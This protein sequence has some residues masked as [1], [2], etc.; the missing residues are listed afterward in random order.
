MHPSDLKKLITGFLILSALSGSLT[1]IF[2]NFDKPAPL[3][4]SASTVPQNQNPLSI[5]K[6]AFVE[7]LPQNSFAPANSQATANQNAVQAGRQTIDT[8]NLTQNF[9]GIFAQQVIAHNPDG[10][11]LDQNGKPAGLNLPNEDSA[12]VLIQQAITSSTF[13]VDETI[14]DS[15]LKILKTYAAR[16]AEDYVAAVKSA[17]ADFA[18]STARIDTTNPGSAPDTLALSQLV[19]ESALL[20]L[21]GAPVPQPLVKFH[22]SLLQ[23]FANQKKVLEIAGNYQTD[24]LKAVVVLKN[25]NE[26]VGRDVKR[27]GDEVRNIPQKISFNSKEDN[28]ISFLINEIFGVKEAKA[29]V[30][31]TGITPVAVVV[32][33]FTLAVF[34]KDV[35]IAAATYG[36]WATTIL[37]YVARVVDWIKTHAYEVWKWVYTTAL[38][39]AVKILIDTFENQVVNWIAGNG[40]PKFI[41]DW[42]G[43]LK[44]VGD[45]AAGQALSDQYPFLCGNIGPLIRVAV[46]PVPNLSTSVRCTLTQIIGNVTGFYNNFQTGG[47]IAYGATLQPQNNFFGGLIQVNENIKRVAADA[48]N[49]AG[50]QSVASKGFLP[51]ATKCVKSHPVCTVEEVNNGNCDNPSATVCDKE[52][53]QTPGATVGESLTKALGWPVE[54]IFPAQRFEELVGA[55]VNA[56]INRMIMSGLSALTEASNPA[57]TNFAN[58]IP[59]GV[60]DP[61]SIALLRSN[62]NNLIAFQQ[63]NGTFQRFQDTATANTQWLALEPQ[64]IT[65]LGQVASSCASLA[66]NSQQKIAALNSLKIDVQTELQNASGTTLQSI[67]SQV[68]NAT[69]AQALSDIADRL[70]GIDL[71]V[72]DINN[73]TA[74]SR[75]TRLQNLQI[76]A[77]ANL[78]NVCN[79]Q[80]I[81]A[82]STLQ[83]IIP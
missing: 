37:N 3:S 1:L 77:Q 75:L 22:R 79:F 73:Q 54:G 30:L 83:M 78:P 59:A 44:D 27:I 62:L 15:D 18:S 53:I 13:A 71:A 11:Q 52:I 14:P 5:G 68:N 8:S 28:K 70:Q 82:T 10:P 64:V 20:K 39:I 26:I 4:F 47:W 40:N 65:L 81:D 55:I 43:F 19:F 72:A 7:Q 29:Q 51:G 63:R 24:P 12:A 32:D 48:L 16:D 80:L 61:G 66:T 60:V 74:A 33:P 69:S 67:Q 6:N 17:L 46:L 23:F 25:E 34:G 38:R 36:T 41:T 2:L 76:S 9:A 42:K 50:L 35:A 45:K 49:A 58:A 57:P 56:S 31:G 21:K